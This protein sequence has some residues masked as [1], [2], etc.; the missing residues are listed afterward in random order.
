MH[1]S[2]HY[3]LKAIACESLAAEATDR[4]MRSAWAE[5]AMEW[6]ALANLVGRDHELEVDE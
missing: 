4:E 2:E 3:R 5:I 1:L 6:H